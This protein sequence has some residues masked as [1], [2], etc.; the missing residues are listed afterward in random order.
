MD[1]RFLAV[2]NE[3]LIGK[4]SESDF[5]SSERK[6]YEQMSES[7][8]K[9]QS[10]FSFIFKKENSMVEF[11]TRGKL[12]VVLTQARM[13]LERF[14]GDYSGKIKI[15]AYLFEDVTRVK[16]PEGYYKRLSQ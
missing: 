9:R 15:E 2:M 6:D 11:Q 12:E 13:A 7:L 16:I 1:K 4:I 14:K 3:T 10:N 8:F 5:C